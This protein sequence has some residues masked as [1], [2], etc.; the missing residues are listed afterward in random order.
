MGESCFERRQ[1]D[2]D[3]GTRL[4]GGALDKILRMDKESAHQMILWH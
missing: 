1:R 4:R 2:G 3:A